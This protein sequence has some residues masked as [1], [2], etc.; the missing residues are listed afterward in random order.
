MTFEQ[1]TIEEMHE[2]S[3]TDLREYVRD[4]YQHASDAGAIR[5]YRAQIGEPKLLPQPTE[6]EFTEDDEE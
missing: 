2:I 3:L 1:K 6:V 5:D 4:I